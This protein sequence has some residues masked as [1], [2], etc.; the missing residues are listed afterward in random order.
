M[1]YW[2][3]LLASAPFFPVAAQRD[4]L[5]EHHQFDS[6]PYRLLRPLNEVAGKRYPLVVF[7][8]GSGERG[9]DNEL[10]L[11]YV[12][13]LFL[14]DTVR[15]KFPCFV[16]LPQCP[17]T[18]RWVN[19]AW[20]SPTHTLRPAPT[21]SL[22]KVME[23]IA[24]VKKQRPINPKRVYVGGLSMGGFGT[25][26]LLARQPT[27]FAAAIP[28]CGGADERTASRIR[29]V[30]LWAFHGAMDSV[31]PP[32]RSRN[33][34]TALR[35]VR[36]KPRYTEYPLVGHDSWVNALAEPELLPWLFAQRLK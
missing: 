31:V 29:H 2:L 22:A 24:E 17:A 33:M 28:I 10:N 35:K 20:S 4:S 1:K 9:T 27:V 15:R 12:A 11:K 30:P 6:L 7:L 25:W 14:N 32:E 36:G 21:A 26:E 18:D 13:S 19:V 5:F 3:W 34:I 8:H 16:L 23:L